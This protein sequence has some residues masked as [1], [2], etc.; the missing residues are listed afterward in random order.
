VERLAY[1]MRAWLD[2]LKGQNPCK[3]ISCCGWLFKMSR[4]AGGG[5]KPALSLARR[6]HTRNCSAIRGEASL[7]IVALV[8]ASGVHAVAQ[9]PTWHAS[10]GATALVE[11]WDRNETRESLTGVVAGVDRQMWRALALRVEG[12][13]LHVAQDAPDAWLGGFTIGTRARWLRVFAHPFFDLGVGV[14][15]A[16]R[17][18]PVRGTAS[19]FL[20]LSG[21]GVEIPARA[22]SL[23]LAA[24]WLHLSNNGRSGRHRNP[25]IQAIGAVVAIRLIPR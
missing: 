15:H 10:V 9:T 11:S 14:S 12:M 25:D 21:G 2:I 19:N 5:A 8:V 3:A 22:F 23:E 6:S 20:I 24:R 7:V 4:P 16:T 13:L 18:I 1:G 17:D